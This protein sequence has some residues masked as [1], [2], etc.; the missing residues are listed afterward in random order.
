[1]IS[2]VV[3]AMALL[4]G[5]TFLASQ[6]PVARNPARNRRLTGIGNRVVPARRRAG[7]HRRGR[8][9]AVTW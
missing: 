2:L 7:A 8:D 5:T 6:Q 1:M 4:G 3:A 9:L